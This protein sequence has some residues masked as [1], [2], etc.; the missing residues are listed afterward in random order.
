[1]A[2]TYQLNVK[3]NGV[4]QAVS[5]IGELESALAA[6]KEELSGL[7]IGSDA[8]QNLAK[9]ART[10]QGELET[11]SEK[12]TNF[13]GN[14]D[15]ITQSVGRLGSTIAGGFAVATAAIGLFGAEGEDLSKAQVKAQQALT[16]AF[17]V[18]TIATNAARISQDLKNVADSLG[19]NIGRIKTATTIS[20]SVV[21]GANTVVTGAQTVATGAAT[22]A[23]WNL[24]AAMLANPIGLVLLG[25]TALVGAL[26]LFSG[27]SE[28]STLNTTKSTEAFIKETAVIK[29]NQSSILELIKGKAELLIIS[30]K[31]ATKR[32]QLENDLYNKLS[33]TEQEFLNERKK[34]N[35]ESFKEAIQEFGRINE[36]YLKTTIVTQKEIIEWHGNSGRTIQKEITKEINLMDKAIDANVKA[37]EKNKEINDKELLELKERFGEEI[38]TEEVAALRLQQLDAKHYLALIDQ[39]EEYLKK[40][41]KLSDDAIKERFESSKKSLQ[42]LLSS[43]EDNI[44]SQIKINTDKNK[45]IKED[46]LKAF[47]EQKRINEKRADDWKK[48]YG[49]IIKMADDAGQKLID[50]QSD[51]QDKIEDEQ[52]KGD[53]ANIELQKKRSLESIELIRSEATAEIEASKLKKAEKEKLIDEINGYAQLAISEETS[54]YQIK[55]DEQTAI[56]KARVEQ[57]KVI[58][59]VLIDEYTYGDNNILDSK[60]ALNLQ[61]QQLE[62]DYLSD[63]DVLRDNV[64]GNYKER[65]RFLLALKIDALNKERELTISAIQAGANQEY[66][67]VVDNLRKQYDIEKLFVGKR[68]DLIKTGTLEELQADYDAAVE[69]GKLNDEEL[70]A[71]KVIL[72]TKKNLILKSDGEIFAITESSRQKRIDAEKATEDEIFAYKVQKLKEASDLAFQFINAGLQIANDINALQ[73]VGLENNLFNIQEN[74]TAQ[75]AS[76]DESYNNELAL[77]NNKLNEGT[78]SQEQYNEQQKALQTDLDKSKVDA[79]H[80]A[81]LESYKAK[82]KAFESDKKLK[83]AQSIIAG[84]Q[85][86]ISAFAGAMQLGPIAGPIVGGILAAAVGVS[87]GIQVSAIKKTKFNE[88]PPSIPQTPTPNLSGGGLG[89]SDAL[90]TGSG[91]GQTFF[92]PSLVG[93]SGGSSGF[94]SAGS[95]P[96]GATKVYVLESDIT[97]VQNK[98]SALESNASF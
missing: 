24:N 85:G 58:N 17:G 53:L 93:G 26:I 52:T 71:Y 20:D 88:S 8:F 33:Q 32:L 66:D 7:D 5:T 90:N 16:L 92:D 45:K 39:Q 38:I 34:R 59:Q 35:D 74:L 4:D 10:L 79:Q 60:K 95:G 27:Q 11:N 75:E 91:G 84:A 76:Y 54:F 68:I 86:A 64:Q 22:A 46:D 87:T 19:I 41:G 40:Q 36:E 82:K 77:L 44:K 6:T 2:S 12:L 89:G 73:K 3:V 80:K 56:D 57:L 25:V 97:N 1:M 18:T 69:S 70:E 72:E 94:Q 65:N 31:D 28:K 42:D 55:I 98:V 47:E 50:I 14:L 62:I 23:Q 63:Q 51:Y 61:L 81:D 29:E 13:N 21:T 37:Y 48:Y 30:E 83:I 49:D 78:I 9:Q 15:N 67:I 96:G 43:L